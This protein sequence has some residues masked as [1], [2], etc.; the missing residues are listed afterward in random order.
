MKILLVD[1]D[2]SLAEV[3]AFVL[4]RAGYLVIL[5][6]DGTQALDLWADEQPDLILLDIQLPDKDGLTV[7]QELRT[8]SS[9]PIIMLT[10]R[11]SDDDIVHGLEIGADDYLTKPF[12]PKQLVA[13]VQAVL[14]RSN[15]APHQVTQ[16]PRLV[17]GALEL[18]PMRQTAQTPQGLVRLTRLEFRLLHYLLINRDRIVPTEAILSHVWGY[19]GTGDRALLKQLVYRLRQKIVHPDP[20]RHYIETVPGLGYTITQTAMVRAPA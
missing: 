19:A 14:R 15:T 6:Y 10:V 13:R 16:A 20:N 18:D 1:D 17:V 3:T 2:S 4:R 9:V 5:A 8:M 12:S 11:D 7:C